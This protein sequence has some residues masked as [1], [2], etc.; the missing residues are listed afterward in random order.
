MKNIFPLLLGILACSCTR[1]QDNTVPEPEPSAYFWRTVLKLDKAERDFLHQ[2]GIKKLY[3]QFFDVEMDP[4]HGPEPTGTLVFGESIPKGLKIIPVVYIEPNC[5]SQPDTLAIRIVR[6]VF[7]MAET[8]DIALSEL[9]I[10][11]DW[12][13][14]T[15]ANYFRLLRQMKDELAQKGHYELSATIRLHQLA[16]EAPPVDYGALM[17][18]NTGNLRDISTTN[19]I[20]SPSSVEPYLKYLETY[21]LPLCAAYPIFSWN[22]LFENGRFRA[23]LRDA[24]LSDTSLYRRMP[25]GHYRVVRSHSL[26]SPDANS[27]GLIVRAGDEVK[28]DAPSTGTVLSVADRLEKRRPNINK[29]IIIYSLNSKD[30]KNIDT[31]EFDKLYCR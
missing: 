10:D 29:Q 15:Q 27:F 21:R 23:I 6:R 9:Q 31:H 25:N 3:T 16:L 26:P 28:V 14:S 24:D 22:L 8:N 7:A 1:T 17:C 4:S 13:A 18:Y 5:L 20:L 30:I 19:S 2:Y 12:T 11:C